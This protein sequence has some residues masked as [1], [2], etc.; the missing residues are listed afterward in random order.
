MAEMRKF[1][2][3]ATRDTASGKITY[4]SFLHPAVLRRYGQFMLK[5]AKQAD[6]TLRPGDNWQKGIPIP[7]YADSLIRHTMDFWLIH[8]GWGAMLSNIEKIDD[9]DPDGLEELLCAILFNTSGYL[10][11]LLQ[12]RYKIREKRNA[13]EA[14]QT[15]H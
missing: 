14:T 4:E 12:K 7:S 2:T 8:R 10:Y 11:E 1:E 6:G 3:G 9:D 15:Q 13:N 5:H